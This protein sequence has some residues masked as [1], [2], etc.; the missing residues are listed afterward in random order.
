MVRGAGATEGTV[1]KGGVGLTD[2]S[3]PDSPGLQRGKTDSQKTALSE[4]TSLCAQGSQ[5]LQPLNSIG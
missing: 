5:N 3:I 1:S 4:I 2:L